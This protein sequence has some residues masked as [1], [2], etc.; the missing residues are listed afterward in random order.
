M[1]LKVMFTSLYI[2]NYIEKSVLPWSVNILSMLKHDIALN[3][4]HITLMI[5]TWEEAGILLLFDE[6]YVLRQNGS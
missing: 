6:S 4:S 1:N 2:G 3:C 5:E